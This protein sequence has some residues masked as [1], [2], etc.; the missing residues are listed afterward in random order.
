MDFQLGLERRQL[1]LCELK[2]FSLQTLALEP[3]AEAKAGEVATAGIVAI[4]AGQT[5]RPLQLAA[6]SVS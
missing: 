3:P 2:I 1:A 4:E 5:A 6:C